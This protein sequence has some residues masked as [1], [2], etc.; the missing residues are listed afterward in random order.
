MAVPDSRPLIAGADAEENASILAKATK[1]ITLYWIFATMS[2][3]SWFV[4]GIPKLF[5]NHPHIVQQPIVITHLT[6]SFLTC[7]CCMFNH[8]RTPKVLGEK[9]KL[10]HVYVGRCGAY[11]S[12]IGA[13]CGEIRTFIEYY[14]TGSLN[15][16]LV[17]VGIWQTYCTVNLV[18]HIRRAKAIQ[19]SEGA[20]DHFKKYMDLHIYYTHALF[21]TACLGPLWSRLFDVDNG[22][23]GVYGRDVMVNWLQLG[24]NT[25]FMIFILMQITIP[26]VLMWRTLNVKKHGKFA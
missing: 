16:F 21:Y 6:C 20:N 19:R 15:V 9:W 4:L 17:A 14:D 24:E 18:K 12:L 13:C 11:F 5:R 1:N 3:M 25:C 22:T 23:M 8:W 10:F 7:L 2:L 26:N